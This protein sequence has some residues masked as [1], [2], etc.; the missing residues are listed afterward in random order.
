MIKIKIK[1]A[2]KRR[3]KVRIKLT[4]E[5]LATIK[6]KDMIFK[7]IPCL[8]PQVIDHILGKIGLPGNERCTV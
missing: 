1:K 2:R 7:L 6:L 5:K 8:F 4:L 3:K